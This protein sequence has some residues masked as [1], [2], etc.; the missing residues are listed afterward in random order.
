ML[1]HEDG[2]PQEDGDPETQRGVDIR[3]IGIELAEGARAIRKHDPALRLA[4]LEV[5][6]VPQAESGRTDP[7]LV[8]Q[9][10]IR[11]RHDLALAGVHTPGLGWGDIEELAIEL[12]DDLDVEA[13]M[14]RAA[15]LFR[16]LASIPSIEGEGG[17][18]L[19][20]C[21]HC[22]PHLV[23]ATNVHTTAARYGINCAVLPWRRLS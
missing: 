14:H 9:L 20:R 21:F 23:L 2:G 12:F 10:D 15:V 8:Y 17:Q 3:S 19:A 22:T 16:N 4:R 18:A 6:E 13:P 11:S 7:P 1:P 5:A